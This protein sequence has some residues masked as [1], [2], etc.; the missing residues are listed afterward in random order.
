[1]TPNKRPHRW[2]GRPTGAPIGNANARRHGMKS[3]GFFVRRRQVGAMLRAARQA[4]TTRNSKCKNGPPEAQ[5]RLKIRVRSRKGWL[6][7]ERV[8]RFAFYPR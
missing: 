1:V 4:S 7:Q 2:T 8:T 5:P 6:R 3:A